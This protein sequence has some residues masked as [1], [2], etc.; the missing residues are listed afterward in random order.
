MTT[1][2]TS[3]D[4]VTFTD[5]DRSEPCEINGGGCPAEAVYVATYRLVSGTVRPC[6][7][8]RRRYCAPHRDELMQRIRISQTFRIPFICPGCMESRW[9]FVEIARLRG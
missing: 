9:E 3:L 1:S 7:K 4:W 2:E 6:C 5:E 8:T